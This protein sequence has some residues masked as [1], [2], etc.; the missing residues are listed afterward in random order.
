MLKS[1]IWPNKNNSDVR[2]TFYRQQ[3]YIC[4]TTTEEIAF[5]SV[6]TQVGGQAGLGRQQQAAT[7]WLTERHGYDPT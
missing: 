6:T 3:Y 4:R 5:P 1:I 2:H 7:P